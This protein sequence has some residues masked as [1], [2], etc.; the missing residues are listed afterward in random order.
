MT[1]T[2]DVRAFYWNAKTRTFAQDAWNLEWV[3]DEYAPRAFP[4]T[5]ES[6]YIKNYATGNQRLF[7]FVERDGVDWVFKS[8]DDDITC[9]I[10]VTPF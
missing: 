5:K 4:D 1:H 7:T 3:D 8:E 2:Y 6:F 10:G 9:L